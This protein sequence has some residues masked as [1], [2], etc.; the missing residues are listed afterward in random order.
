MTSQN[1]PND[2]SLIEQQRF[3]LLISA[4][5]DYAIYML[6]SGGH[7][8]SWNLGAERFK[9]YKGEEIIGQHFSRFYTSED[10][11]EGLPAIALKTAETEGKFE[12]EGWRLRKDGSRFWASVVIDP[13]RS[14]DGRL[15][16]FAKITRDIGERRASEEALRQSE[17]QFQL[18]VQG[19]TDYAIYMLDK[20]GN[21]TNW[22][23]GAQRIK[24]Y[25]QAE[26][27][28]THFSRFY[29]PEDQAN[30]IP[31]LALATA[32]RDGRFEQ[33]GWRLRKDGS[34]FLAHVII[35]LI[36]NSMGE[37]VGYAKITRD[38]TARQEAALVLKRTEEALQHAQ[39]M[40]TLGKL[41][42][43]VAHDF[44]NLLQVIFGNLQLLSREVRGN[45]RAERRV[46]NAL[47]GVSR[48]AKLASHLLAFARRQALDPKVVNIGRFIFT[49]E[50]ILQRALGEAV[51][52]EMVVGGGLW[53]CS[54]DIAQ[55]E[56][57]LLNL[58]INAR[59]AMKGVGKLTVEIGNAFLD[60]AYARAHAEVSPGQYVMLAVSDTGSGMSAEVIRQA[61]E[62]FF[63]TKPEGQGTGL[64][65]S[66]VYGFV[67]QSGG[68]IKIYSELSHGT[69][70][71]IYLPRSNE[72]EDVIV[73]VDNKPV[74]GGS[75]TILVAEDDEQVRATVVEILSELGYQVLR[76]DDAASA[77]A[78][79]QSGIKID[80]LFTDVVMPG[81]MRSPELAR[82]AREVAPG[83]AVLFTS[84]Y[85]QNAIVHGGRLDPGVEL[86]PKP[87]SREDL[88]RRVR[89]V[90]ANQQHRSQPLEVPSE[91]HRPSL[92]P[93]GDVSVSPLKILLVEDDDLIRS[94]TAELLH[95]IG[96][97]VTQ[98]A[99]G[100]W[101][102]ERLSEE[103]FEVLIVDIG[104]DDI[105]GDVLAKVALEKQ[106]SMSIVFATG[107]EIRGAFPKAVI[108][109]KPYDL[110]A[111]K[112]A[113]RGVIS[114]RGE[115]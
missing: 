86:L 102:L 8:V 35:D 25:T 84:G 30:G 50:D 82:K 1:L 83:L 20:S 66:M 17:Q 7:V 9:G 71:K 34:R 114:N 81:P 51:E 31:K 73:S 88:A 68:H 76:A 106:P 107:Q 14:N 55:V 58:A 92:S 53:N 47:A 112:M 42:G 109:R 16:G 63:T 43:G 108:L 2:N 33:E 32:M 15:L 110:G 18:L 57:A 100:K 54:V 105:A 64:G 90:I 6:D 75:E 104:L 103:A 13:I 27:L 39:K 96:H 95:D 22:N 78:I 56:N 115:A 94:A 49:M 41:T 87:Y 62:P 77:L 65:L 3:Q 89:Q 97:S 12:T 4:I 91:P 40:E 52:V 80:L 70:V 61:F 10:R 11:A 5:R 101:A 36:R 21:I 45:E 24:G 26:V 113:L 48:G 59:D 46:Q 85:T 72:T 111:L 69:T 67:K 98:A 38:I 23:A 28:G 19:V 93:N 99:T 29:T 60:D 79:V 37:F 44:N 74:V